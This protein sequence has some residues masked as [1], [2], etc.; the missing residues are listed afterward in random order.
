[1]ISSDNLKKS[2]IA[3]LQ[4]NP[5]RKPLLV[6][7]HFAHRMALA[8]L[9]TKS[10]TASLSARLGITPEDIA[11]DTIA[12]LFRT[13]ENYSLV[14]LRTY[15]DRYGD[16]SKL[17]DD[18]VLYALRRLVFSAV[19]HHVFR[20]Y[21]DLDPGLARLIRNIK[22]T[23]KKES[24]IAIAEIRGEQSLVPRT[25]DVLRPDLPWM[26]PEL[27]STEFRPKGDSSLAEMLAALAL[28]LKEQTEYCRAVP[29]LEAALLIR[30]VYAS[31]AGRSLEETPESGIMEHEI[32][33][34]IEFVVRELRQAKTL[35]YT[36]PGKLTQQEVDA[37]MLAV[38]DLLTDEF[39]NAD[40]NATNYFARLQQHLPEVTPDLYKIKHRVILEYLAKTAKMEARRILIKEL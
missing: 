2:L 16:L 34:V 29:L 13:D 4:P 14:E 32:Q 31:Q 33:S 38:N 39:L 15:F 22:L 8:Y 18:D 21:G 10:G 23:A 12:E 1:M 11:Y 35:S 36:R 7:I 9:R 37:H 26:P 3:V 6:F 27:L 25:Q 20:C 5:Q 28:V 24:T 30:S 40:G 19:N 17:S